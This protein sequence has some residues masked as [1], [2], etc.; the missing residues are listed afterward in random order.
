M[1]THRIP[2]EERGETSVEVT[3]QY[4][5]ERCPGPLTLGDLAYS[6]T[7]LPGEKVR[8]FTTDRRTRFTFDSATNLSHR[9]E[10]TSEEQFYMSSMADFMSDLSV[11]DRATSTNTA[12]GS[13]SGHAE[14][15]GAIDAFFSGPSVD[16]SGS[17]SARTTHDF[18][19]SLR[20]HAVSS[21]RR[22]VQGARAASS[23]SIGEVSTRSHAEGTSEDHFES[24][25][26]EFANPNRCHAITFLFYR[27]NKTQ[28]VRFSL[29][30]I[31]RRV[32]DPAAPTKVVNSE[33]LARGG[34]SAIPDPILATRADRLD[35]ERLG[36]ESVQLEREAALGGEPGVRASRLTT[37]R[38]LRLSTPLSQETIDAAL[39]QVER[40]LVDE[41]LLDRVG[42]EVSEEE[43][44]RLSFEETSS[45]PTAGVIVKGCLD[46]CS[47]C[48]PEM[49]RQIDLE[50]RLLERQIELLDKSQEYRC[51]PD[52]HHGDADGKHKDKDDK[53][54]KDKGKGGGKDGDA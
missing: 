9:S 2:S 42:G 12:T 45:L 10:Q 24:S 41:G 19:R 33:F 48:E 25:S 43:K 35:V 37:A 17:F 18:T 32:L 5:L 40:D 21:D 30:S 22:S 8:L 53:D 38:G 54:D 29:E 14:T 3:L 16:V 4:R 20:Q 7:L 44:S 49:E 28:T 11:V 26:R 46:E 51:C 47:I 27:I 34:I 31:E 13:T 15:N 52:H 6:T 50:L 1:L 39:E 23:V 36:R